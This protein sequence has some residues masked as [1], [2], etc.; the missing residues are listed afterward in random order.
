MIGH[1]DDRW[2]N[3]GEMFQAFNTEPDV[4]P[5][6]GKSEPSKND[7]SDPAHRQ[8]LG[9][10]RKG[11]NDFLRFPPDDRRFWKSLF[12]NRGWHFCFLAFFFDPGLE[13]SNGREPRKLRLIQIEPESELKSSSM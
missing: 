10:V 12:L 13:F 2:V 11:R 8:E 4:M 7:S 9:P 6:K 1:E 3:L 5:K